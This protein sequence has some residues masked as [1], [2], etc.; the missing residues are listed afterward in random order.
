MGRKRQS[1]GSWRTRGITSGRSSVEP[2]T[3]GVLLGVLVD[4]CR[5]RQSST[6]ETLSTKTAARWFKGE[7]IK[8]ENQREMVEAIAGALVDRGYLP[9]TIGRDAVLTALKLLG[10]RWDQIGNAMRSFSVPVRR[11]GAMVFSYLRLV[12]IDFAYRWAALALLEGRTVPA[13]GD[14]RPAWS[15]SRSVGAQLSEWIQAAEPRPTRDRIAEKLGYSQNTIDDWLAGNKQP[16]DDSLHNLAT[17][18]ASLLGHNPAELEASLARR[19]AASALCAKLD[20]HLQSGHRGLDYAEMLWS[21]LAHLARGAYELLAQYFAAELVVAPGVEKWMLPDLL[22]R[23]VEGEFA[24]RLTQELW[25][26]EPSRLWRAELMASLRPWEDRLQQVARLLGAKRQALLAEIERQGGEN[27]PKKL[28]ELVGIDEDE[29]FEGLLLMSLT[30]M[31]SWNTYDERHRGGSHFQVLPQTNKQKCN[32]RLTQ[33]DQAS[34]LGDE[35][36]A[37]MHLSRAVELDPENPEAR[38]FLGASLGQLAEKLFLSSPHQWP[39]ADQ[40]AQEAFEHL[41]VCAS[42]RPRWDRPV[43]EIGIILHNIGY[44]ARAREYFVSIEDQIDIVDGHYFQSMGVSAYVTGHV[45]LALRCFERVLEFRPRHAEALDYA[46]RCHLLLGDRRAARRRA[47]EA[48]DLGAK[49]AMSRFQI[50]EHARRCVD[51]ILSLG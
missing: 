32:N 44:P 12:A 37:L 20:R 42:L 35:E 25:D 13:P 2:P 18:F 51:E 47:K 5:L 31:S 11:T 16:A 10:R 21:G 41:E 38:F 28:A 33:A 26:E 1:G 3:A 9:E 19:A 34:A 43:V 49:Q 4:V 29:M 30:D 15:T 14:G 40:I 45:D 23:G 6:A 7:R 46:A 48:S 8:P 24:S 17:Y 36:T 50:A 27:I 22:V 39:D